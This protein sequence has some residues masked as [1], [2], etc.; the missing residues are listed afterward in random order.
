MMLNYYTKLSFNVPV[1]HTVNTET[2]IPNRTN[3]NLKQ[4]HDIIYNIDFFF[5][6]CFCTTSRLDVLDN[7]N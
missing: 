2:D 1:A 6:C 4:C 7:W 5:Q 3:Q